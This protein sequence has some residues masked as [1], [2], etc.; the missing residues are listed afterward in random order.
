MHASIDSETPP[1]FFAGSR[2]S[3]VRRQMDRRLR[4]ER[5]GAHP[6][7]GQGEGFHGLVRTRFASVVELCLQGGRKVA[8]AAG[9]GR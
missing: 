5:D 2:E 3:P 1:S 6:G 9:D 8:A 4:K 7:P